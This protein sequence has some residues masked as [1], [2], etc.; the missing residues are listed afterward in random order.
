MKYHYA[1]NGWTVIVDENINDLSTEDILRVGRLI[2]SNMVVV[3]KNQKLTTEDELRFCWIIGNVQLTE[4]DRTKHISLVDGIL[5]VTGQKNDAG[6]PGL[7][8][9]T[10]ALDWHSNQASS[11]KRMP[12]IWLYGLEGTKGSRTSWINMIEAYKVLSVEDSMELRY[13]NVY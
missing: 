10:S 1:D 5:R 13:K 4:Y 6:E 7:F 11:K 8:G 2:V 3:F 12:L 9:H